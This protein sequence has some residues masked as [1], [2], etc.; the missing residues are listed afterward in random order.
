M[1]GRWA[2]ALL[3]RSAVKAGGA[4]LREGG[5]VKTLHFAPG[6]TA[7]LVAVKGAVEKRSE[8]LSIY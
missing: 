1:R 8:T 6:A 7:V 4:S 5:G 2:E 3:S